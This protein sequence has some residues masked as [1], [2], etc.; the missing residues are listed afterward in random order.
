MPP[1]P[2]RR[3]VL[4]LLLAFQVVLL[5]LAA[6]A[7]FV[8]VVSAVVDRRWRL[9]RLASV[10]GAYVAVEW[11]ALG[12]LFGV[13][14][15][16]PVRGAAWAGAANLRILHRAL[17]RFCA[18]PR[19]ALG[20]RIEV[21][22]PP[23]GRPLSEPAPALVLARHGGVGDS[24]GLV[25]LLVDRY[26]RRPRIALKD[27]LAWDPL[28]DVVL[29]RLG[30]TFLPPVSRRKGTG[31]SLVGALAESLEPGDALLLFPEGRNWTP[32]RRKRAIRHLRSER[33]H[34]EAKHAALMEHVLPPRWGGVSAC[35]DARPDLPVVV[36]AHTGLDKITTFG[37][38]WAALP[39]RTPMTVR[40]WR[41]PPA[42][43][44][45]EA[46]MAWLVREWAVVDEWIDSRLPG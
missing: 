23:D 43:E 3:I 39:F 31:R 41:P 22:E 25:W 9:V 16:R 28:I 45:E 15:L 13:W 35:L 24:V 5:A 32:V 8:G 4:P 20:F 2:V 42:P 38:L 12:A 29:T 10:A 37:Q 6:A 21:T 1:R 11:S 26:H 33:R 36:V 7:A 19:R 44:D 30:A 34:A 27:L 18:A 17:D 40:W 46:R 14:L